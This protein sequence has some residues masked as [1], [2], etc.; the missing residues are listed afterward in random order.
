MEPT[1]INNFQF[2]QKNGCDSRIKMLGEIEKRRAIEFF[3][4][5]F[6]KTSIEFIKKL[7][8]WYLNPLSLA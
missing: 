4:M 1:V 8:K 7:S 5:K 3:L 6:C 2:Y